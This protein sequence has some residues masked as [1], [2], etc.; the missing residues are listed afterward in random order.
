MNVTPGRMKME[1]LHSPTDSTRPA[2]AQKA[3]LVTGGAGF[4]G[5]HLVEALLSAGS[6]VTVVDDES[7][8]RFENLQRPALADTVASK[9][10]T[11]VRGS[12]GDL[13]LVKSLLSNVDEV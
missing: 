13:A 9:Q 8:G 6:R 1:T 5:S 4:I 11:L 10:L 3:A 7:T 2:A 12:I